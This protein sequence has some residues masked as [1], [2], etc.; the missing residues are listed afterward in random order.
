V[1][2]LC[3]CVHESTATA[4]NYSSESVNILM[5]VPLILLY[6]D[7]SCLK[8]KCWLSSCLVNRAFVVDIY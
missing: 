6:V 4:N 3:V 2:T 5:L 7:L 1:C 8:Y